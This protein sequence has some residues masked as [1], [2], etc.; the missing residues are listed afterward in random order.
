MKTTQSQCSGT[1]LMVP[2]RHFGFNP[3]TGRDNA[4]QHQPHLTTEALQQQAMAEF[5]TMVATLRQQGIEVLLLD[6]HHGS[7]PTPDAVFPNNWFSTAANGQLVLYPMAT[8]NRQAEVQPGP[9]TACLSAAGYQVRQQLDLR[10]QAAPGQALEGTGALVFDHRLGKVYAARSQ[11]CEPALFR[12][13]PADYRLV[14]FDTDCQGMPVYHTNVLL[15]IGEQFA[16]VCPEVIADAHRDRVL[17]E[18]AEQR[19]LILISAQQMQA[20]AA[21]LL[22]LRSKSGE[23]LIALSATAHQALLASQRAQLSQY[24][25]LL[26]CRVDTIEHVGGGSVRCILAEIFLPKVEGMV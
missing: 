16:V 26:P 20:F 17:A 14:D 2:P 5:D 1:V 24:G 10:P 15:S 13:L 8:P 25:R 18:L 23:L 6:A 9:L 12:L 7:Q 19:E 11:R 21:N 3:E 4:F 22:Q